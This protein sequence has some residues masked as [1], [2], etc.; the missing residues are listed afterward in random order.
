MA[1]QTTPKDGKEMLRSVFEFV[2]FWLMPLASGFILLLQI[3]MLKK[4]IPHSVYLR[5]LRREIE[6]VSGKIDG[7]ITL[8]KAGKLNTEDLDLTLNS[9]RHRYSEA[10]TCKLKITLWSCSRLTRKQVTDSSNAKLVKAL[11]K[12]KIQLEKETE[13][14]W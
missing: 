12:L 6:H 14:T 8:C 2:N 11:Q 7:Y 3:W 13:K 10:L 4:K 1:G 5:D 9:I